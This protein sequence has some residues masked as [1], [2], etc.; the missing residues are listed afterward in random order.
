MNEKY[1]TFVLK[2][3]ENKLKEYMTDEEYFEFATEVS[4]EGFKMEVESLEEG[5]FKNLILENFN[6]IVE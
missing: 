2:Q 4:R 1:L 5:E 6:K 3:Y